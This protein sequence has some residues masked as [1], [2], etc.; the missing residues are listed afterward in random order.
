MDSYNYMETD[1]SQQMH[2]KEVVYTCALASRQLS[3]LALYFLMR[4]DRIVRG[5]VTVLKITSL[6]IQ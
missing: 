6:Y 5:M 1:N 3:A 4:L 2:H